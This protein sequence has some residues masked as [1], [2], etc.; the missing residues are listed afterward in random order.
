MGAELSLISSL[1]RIRMVSMNPD[2]D[3]R[4][5]HLGTQR[6]PMSL[7]EFS[8]DRPKLIV[9]RLLRAVGKCVSKLGKSKG[10]VDFIDILRVLSLCMWPVFSNTERYTLAHEQ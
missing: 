10:S 7:G 4:T 5:M 8:V 2:L 1:R 9:L 6:E 3:R